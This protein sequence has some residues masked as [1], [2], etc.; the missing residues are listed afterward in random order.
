MIIHRGS[1]QI[2]GSCVEIATDRCR[3]IIDVG[4]PLDASTRAADARRYYPEVAGLFD[5]G[6]KVDCLLLS[7]AHCD[8]SGLIAGSRADIPVRL[9]R[10]TS[11][12]LMAGSLFAQQASLPRA[13]QVLCQSGRRF[14]VGDISVTPLNVDHSAFDA[15]AFLIE[16]GG[17]RALYSGDLRL[18]GRKP[19][20][21]RRLI[22]AAVAKPLDVVILEGTHLGA[23]RKGEANLTE[24]EMEDVTVGKALGA[25][26]PVLAMFSPMNIDRLVSYI[27][28]AMRTKRVLV[29]DPYA[30]FVMYLARS[31]AAL[32]DPFTSE[33]IRIHVPPRFWSSA[34]GRRISGKFRERMESRAVTT[35]ELNRSPGWLIV[36]RARMLETMFSGS[37]PAGSLCLYSYWKGYLEK[38][39]LV[40]LRRRIENAGAA[41]E[42]MHASGHIYRADIQYLLRELNPRMVVPI[43]TTA[44]TEFISLTPNVRLV[45]DGVPLEV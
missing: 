7:H 9:S 34:A 39:E 25:I 14:V 22:A 23:G 19:G 36:F 20:M 24:S 38:P 6:P 44:P 30:A 35:A 21:A 5:P 43:H 28:V 13:R 37:V 45:N 16:A 31:Q 41:F 8:H 12:M 17:K 11:K 27:R 4:L 10:G 2:G 33:L 40:E 26:G 18:H 42:P 29:L 1:N 3:L 15:L 32:P